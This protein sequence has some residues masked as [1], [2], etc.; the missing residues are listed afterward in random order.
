M[1]AS[2]MMRVNLFL[3][4][5][6]NFKILLENEE[7]TASNNNSYRYDVD[8]MMYDEDEAFGERSEFDEE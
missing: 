5:L 2:A 8:V 1:R 7:P 6:S 4:F 3:L